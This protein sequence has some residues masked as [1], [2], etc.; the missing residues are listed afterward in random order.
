MSVIA[1]SS[2]A[3]RRLAASKR[4]IRDALIDAVRRSNSSLRTLASDHHNIDDQGSLELD[5]DES[6]SD[7]LPPRAPDIAEFAAAVV[8]GRAFDVDR[9][10]LATLQDSSRTTIIEVPDSAWVEPVADLIR[11]YV[12]G[13]SFTVNVLE[14]ASH[15]I[16]PAGTVAMFRGT[17]NTKTKR[18]PD[19][20]KPVASAVRRRCALLGIAFD[21]DRTL[22][23]ALLRLADHRLVLPR[24]DADAIA[25]II[26]AVTGRRCAVSIDETNA[27]RVTLADLKLAIR[28]DLGAER[29]CRRLV[30]ILGAGRS[31]AADGPHLA[32]LHG[33]G[34]AKEWGLNLAADLKAYAAGQLTW[35]QIDRG[36]LITGAPGTGKT[37]FARA[38]AREAS[39]H[40]TATSYGQ[41]QSHKDGHLGAVTRAIRNTF[42][43]AMENRPAILFIDEI[44]TI[45]TRGSAAQYEEW[46]TAITNTLLECLDGYDQREGVVVIAACNNPSK[47]DPALVR[48]GRLDRHIEIPLPEVADLIG[49]FRTHLGQDL[50]DADLR[51]AALA[52]RGGTGADVERIV[53]EARGRARREGF[54]LTLPH[55]LEAARAG[56]PELPADVR[57]RV[58]T[59]EAGHAVAM[60]ALGIGEPISLSINTTGGLTYSDPVQTLAHTRTYLEHTLVRMLAGRAAEELVHCEVTAGAGGPPSSDL[61]RATDLAL[62]LET[63]YGLGQS[64][65]VLIP[66]MEPSNLAFHRDI[67]DAVR[68]TLNSAYAHAT[69]LL[70]ANRA[71]LDSLAEALFKMGYLDRGEIT[72]VL[73][74]TPLILRE[75]AAPSSLLP[76]DSVTPHYIAPGAEASPQDNDDTASIGGSSVM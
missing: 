1:T 50:I 76:I 22:P 2:M 57:R 69:E 35:A 40:F 71:A 26:R 6:C 64:G 32:N 8:L 5:G 28:A 54:A 66:T 46:W 33:L 14:L 27:A 4:S 70:K 16:A 30:R 44:D 59:H 7:P 39:V 20:D 23:T 21:P 12:I 72:A 55:L 36:C 41:W 56:A 75:G 15:S 42:Q 3:A 48:S 17:S 29:S 45:P 43:E 38:L 65:L 13:P 61:G 9:S 47:L 51:P 10:V 49:I 34:A 60:L 53:R 62:R 25:A 19:D 63:V 37:S 52:T 58:A 68:T 73:A 18:S 74:K 24:L 11:Q 67:H 31:A